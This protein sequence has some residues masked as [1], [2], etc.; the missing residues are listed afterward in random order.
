MLSKMVSKIAAFFEDA[1]ATWVLA[2]E[3]EFDS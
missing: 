1:A 3:V 2:L